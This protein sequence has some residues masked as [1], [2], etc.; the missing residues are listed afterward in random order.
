MLDDPKSKAFVSNFAGQWLFLRNLDQVKPD[1]DVFPEFDD[2]LRDAFQQETELFFDSVLRENRRVTGAA[3]R[4]VHV[5]QS[6]PGRA[7]WH[8]DVYGPQFRARGTDRSEARR[9]AG[10]GQHSDRDVVPEPHL[11]GAARQVG[12]RKSARL[13]AAPA[14][15]RC[16][17][18]RAARQGRQ[19][20]RMREAMEQHRANAVCASC[21][22]R[23]DPH[24][25][26]AGELRRCRRVARRRTTVR[27]D[28]SGS[29]R[30]ARLPGPA[31]LK[32]LLLDR[33]TRRV[34]VDVHREADDLRSRPRPGVVRSAGD[35]R[36]RA[37]RRQA[38]H[39]HT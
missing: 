27:I 23:M 34:R 39:I 15:A 19:A 28:A 29:C 35:A 4:Q 24:R 7:L 26:R 17:G 21:H 2:S 3:R 16:S 14:A 8:P 37:R 12:S 11:G 1:P 32:K 9:P 18:A 25:L 30:T 33:V 10:A 31:G 22:S 36:H 38:D 6:A 5:P 20:A 13:A